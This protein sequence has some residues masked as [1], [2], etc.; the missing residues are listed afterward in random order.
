MMKNSN[1]LLGKVAGVDGLKTGFTSNAGFCLAATARRDGHRLIIVTMGSPDSK[2]RDLKIAALFEQYFAKLPAS[3]VSAAPVSGPPATPAPP[4]PP[5]QT[6]P[7][8]DGAPLRP[9]G[10]DIRF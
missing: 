5:A 4:A 6:P 3:P 7:P 9:G 2:S 10:P 1:N 8:Q